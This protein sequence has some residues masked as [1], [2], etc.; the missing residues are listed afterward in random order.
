[1][2][3]FRIIYSISSLPSFPLIT[4]LMKATKSNILKV[5]DR[6]DT[7][8]PSDYAPYSNEKIERQFDGLNGVL[9]GLFV[10]ST[11]VLFAFLTKLTGFR[12]SAADCR[13]SLSSQNF[14]VNVTPAV[15]MNI[16]VIHMCCSI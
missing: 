11:I 9:G 5:A 13:V 3:I 14:L 16:V 2:G 4:Q 1:M 7:A 10:A 8:R 12:W 6:D 15:Q